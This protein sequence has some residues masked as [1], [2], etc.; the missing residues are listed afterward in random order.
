MVGVPS[1]SP[2]SAV[3]FICHVTGSQSVASDRDFGVQGFFFCLKT[4][5]NP[6]TQKITTSTGEKQTKTMLSEMER[7]EI[8]AADIRRSSLFPLFSFVWDLMV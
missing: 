1:G 2:R 5:I 6:F 4:P 7:M 3:L 8:R